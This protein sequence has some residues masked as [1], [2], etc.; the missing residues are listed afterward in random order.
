MDSYRTLSGRLS[1]SGP[2]S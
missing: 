2:V 1:S